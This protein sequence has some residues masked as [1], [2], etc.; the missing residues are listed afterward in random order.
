MAT[1]SIAIAL[2]L[3]SYS[4]SQAANYTFL[5]PRIYS[6]VQNVTAQEIEVYDLG[7]SA[8]DL[9]E[10][11]GVDPTFGDSLIEQGFN[12]SQIQKIFTSALLKNDYEKMP[13]SE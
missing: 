8:K 2:F 7:V 11:L 5:K 13:L 6:E 3:S 12:P 1:S 4:S 10:D 9:R